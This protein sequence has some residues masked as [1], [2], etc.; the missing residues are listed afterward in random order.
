MIDLTVS[1]TGE[2]QIKDF[3]KEGQRAGQKSLAR[4]KQNTDWWK[5]LHVCVCVCVCVCV[6][7]GGVRTV[8]LL[9]P[10]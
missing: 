3:K 4:T 8:Q 7:G 5:S 2:R 6:G 10:S 1:C 9:W